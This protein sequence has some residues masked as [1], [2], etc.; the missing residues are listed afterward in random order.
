MGCEQIGKNIDIIRKQR[1][2]SK[3]EFASMMGTSTA[4]ITSR[5]DTGSMLTSSLYETAECLGCDVADLVRTS[6]VRK[7]FHSLVD[8][9]KFYPYN[10]IALVLFRDRK[11]VRENYEEVK[12]KVFEVYIP[13][14]LEAIDTRLTERERIVVKM[15]YDC[16]MTL[17][18]VAKEFNVTRER[19]RQ[20]EQKAMRKLRAPKSRRMWT[21]DTENNTKE[22]LVKIKTL[23]DKLCEY[24]QN[25]GRII[26]RQLLEPINTLELSVR[27][28]NCLARAGVKTIGDLVMKTPEELVNVRNLGRRSYEEIISKLAE[29]GLELAGSSL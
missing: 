19:I 21:F 11:T 12:N 13:G 20:I 22:L 27:S 7:T 8:I 6:G 2:L 9:L 18:D 14:F 10:L 28:Y 17:D 24:E 23:E 26:D 25:A 5:I 16:D 29:I 15:R 1:G 4:C 3:E